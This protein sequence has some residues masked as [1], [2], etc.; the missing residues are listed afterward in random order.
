MLKFS[1]NAKEL[2]DVVRKVSAAIDKK[3][4]VKQL[5]TIFFLV[6][7]RTLKVIGTN[8]E[9]WLEVRTDCIW[10]D[11]PG[12]IGI[13]HDDMKMILKMS[14]VLSFE[15]VSME[16]EKMVSVKC[17]KRELTVQAA[18][19]TDYFVPTMDNTEAK[20][21]ETSESWLY[22][23]VSRL[24][25]FVSYKEQGNKMMNCIN[26]NTESERVTALDGHRIGM[27]Q[28]K[29]QNIYTLQQNVNLNAIYA[30]PTLKVVL[31]KK[32]EI[33]KV[34]MS[35]DGKWIKFSGMDFTYIIRNVEGMYFDVDKLISNKDDYS[36]TADRE[37]LLETIKYSADLI[38]KELIP[39]AFHEAN[40]KLYSYT[41]VQKYEALEEVDVRNLKM[42]ENFYIGFNP[43]YWADALSMADADEVK[44][45]GGNAKEPVMI[46]GNEYSFFVLPVH[47]G[48]ADNGASILTRMNKKFEN[49]A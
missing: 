1:I 31:D 40:G 14:G 27:R 37:K 48:C 29:N 16:T 36:F 2:N 45:N 18:E 10:D 5:R 20:V 28:I 49:V 11:Q 44:V 9:Q 8:M 32:S 43:H 38:G 4:Y 17:G 15:D 23:T 3:A 19:C 22:D 12:V 25:T 24:A 39:F 35:V 42:S 47:I 26:F 34:V 30:T 21:L 33:K 7:D 13:E 41:L 6:E 46:Y